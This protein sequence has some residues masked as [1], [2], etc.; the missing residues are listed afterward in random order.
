MPKVFYVNNLGGGFADH[1]EIR[2]GT[3][4]GQFFTQRL[5]DAEPQDYLIRVNRLPATREQVLVDGDRITITPV[6]VD[7][8][9]R[10][11]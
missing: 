6:K 3:T 10:R 4:V 8:A 2:E 5:P 1:I 9:S 11:R 7:G